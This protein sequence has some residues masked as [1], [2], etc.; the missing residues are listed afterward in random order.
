MAD[1][2]LTDEMLSAHDAVPVDGD[3]F[4]WFDISAG[5]WK[6][7]T[8]AELLALIVS[9]GSPSVLEPQIVRTTGHYVPPHRT[10]FSNDVSGATDVAGTAYF[11]YFT[12]DCPLSAITATVRTAVAGVT[13]KMALYLADDAGRMPKTLV[14]GFETDADMGVAGAKDFD[15]ATQFD[16]KVSARQGYWVALV[17]SGASIRHGMALH[18]SGNIVADSNG[19]G[20]SSSLGRLIATLPYATSWPADA[21]TLTFSDTGAALTGS[22][23]TVLGK[24]VRV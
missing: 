1:R 20:S 2:F 21:S 24:A 13:A 10:G 23:G 11:H 14:E 5:A 6:Y 22:P 19:V 18:S 9:G 4:A 12:A 15:L 16:P 8:K 17:S 3:K 7:L